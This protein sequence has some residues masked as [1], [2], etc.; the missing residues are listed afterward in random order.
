MFSETW[1]GGGVGGFACS[2]FCIP[3]QR[4]L[5]TVSLVITDCNIRSAS[6]AE[7]KSQACTTVAQQRGLSGGGGRRGADTE[8]QA[9]ELIWFSLEYTDLSSLQEGNHRTE[10]RPEEEPLR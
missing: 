9:P 6:P 4:S 1:G 10:S 5:P 8:V 2:F 3:S 7:A